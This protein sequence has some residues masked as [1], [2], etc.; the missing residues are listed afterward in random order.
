MHIQTAGPAHH[1]IMI[2]GPSHP[3]ALLHTLSRPAPTQQYFSNIVRKWGWIVED[4]QTI[5]YNTDQ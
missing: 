2:C 4:M 5:E 3:P 1:L